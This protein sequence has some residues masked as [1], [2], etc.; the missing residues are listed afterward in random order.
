M[1]LEKKTKKKKKKK[2]LHF[3]ITEISYWNALNPLLCDLMPV[4]L[5]KLYIWGSYAW[6][7]EV[8]AKWFFLFQKKVQEFIRAEHL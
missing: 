1:K 4:R 5:Y 2:Q 6:H 7:F 8:L 3:I